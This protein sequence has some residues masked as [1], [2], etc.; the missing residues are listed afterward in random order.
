MQ[1]NIIRD[2]S[3]CP[4]LVQMAVRGHVL[5]ARCNYRVP[6]YSMIKQ[7]AFDVI[8]ILVPGSIH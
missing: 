5:F 4:H 8:I 1:F 7:T 3:A 6:M 2:H